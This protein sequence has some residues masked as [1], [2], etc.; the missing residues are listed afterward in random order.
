MNII[1][2][3]NQR[4]DII[5]DKETGGMRNGDNVIGI[6]SKPWNKTLKSD[7]PQVTGGLTSGNIL[8]PPGCALVFP[9][10]PVSPTPSEISKVLRVETF[11]FITKSDGVK[12]T[13]TNEDALPQYGSSDIL[14]PTTVSYTNLFIN[15]VLQPLIIYKVSA[16]VLI[17]DGVPERGLPLTLQ[18]IRIYHAERR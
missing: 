18:F 1:S 6:T 7:N 13:Y 11:Q 3:I 5:L 17:I 14:D 10:S 8:L 12:S 4:N 15:G 16:G 2:I 9:S